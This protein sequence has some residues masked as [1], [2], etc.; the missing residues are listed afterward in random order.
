MSAITA[1]KRT[2]FKNST[3]TKLRRTGQIPAVVYGKDKPTKH[4]FV[5]SI[6]FAKT[7]KENGRNGILKI[8][9]EG[10]KAESVILQ[11]AQT[12]PLKGTILH[13]D[14]FVVDMSSTIDVEV[15]VAL[16]GEAKGIKDG[17]VLQQPLH[18]ISVRSLPQ[19]IPAK[20]EIDISPYDIG[21]TI[22]V[23][24]IH[25]NGKFEVLS[26]P[27][28]VIASILQPRVEQ[29]IDSGEVQSED[30]AEVADTEDAVNTEE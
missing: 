23:G 2:D 3:K 1:K 21:D 24:D 8:E 7:V 22:V 16:V 15:P 10:E 29:N 6:D 13:A 28:M 14:F 20:I 9:I 18:L 30:E 26:D 17:G 12:D 4:I 11:D 5:N 27:E 25:T 19:D